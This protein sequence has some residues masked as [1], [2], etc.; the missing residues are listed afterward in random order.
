M[1]V[2]DRELGRGEGGIGGGEEKRKWRGQT[3]ERDVYFW[4]SAE[5]PVLFYRFTTAAEGVLGDFVLGLR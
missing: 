3:L 1:G 2:S 4:D 5:A